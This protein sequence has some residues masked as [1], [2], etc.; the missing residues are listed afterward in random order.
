MWKEDEEFDRLIDHAGLASGRDLFRP[1]A[2]KRLGVPSFS[3]AETDFRIPAHM[4]RAFHA[5]I[6]RGFCGYTV[7]EDEAYLRAIADWMHARRGWAV[8]TEWIVPV[9]GVLRTMSMAVRAFSRPGEGVLLFSPGY[10]AYEGL[11]TRN[12][13]RIV[14]IPLHEAA[15]RFLPDMTALEAQ[16]RRAENTMLFLCNAHNPT[17]Q[18]WPQAFLE[19]VAAWAREYGVFVVVDETFADLCFPETPMTNYGQIAAAED[20]CLVIQ[21]IS[22]AFNVTGLNAANAILPGAAARER[23]RQTFLAEQRG[24][25]SI[26]PFVRRAILAGY[27]PEGAAWLERLFIYVKQN[28]DLTRRF[29]SEALPQVRVFPCDCAYLVWTDWRAL[30]LSDAELERF[31]FDEAAFCVDMGYKYG[32]EGSGFARIHLGTSHANVAAGLLRLQ[33]AARARGFGAAE[34]FRPEGIFLQGSKKS[35]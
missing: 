15:G 18:V 5:L 32:P 14:R 33:E 17:M 26:E 10:T 23:F 25:G 6:D 12:G 8:Q 2:A 27:S 16:M 24:S 1:E 22:K 4:Q 35:D 28:M 13:R 29:F 30:G 7:A 20:N 11:I 34:P 9:Y 31:L 19:Q 3:F 21:A